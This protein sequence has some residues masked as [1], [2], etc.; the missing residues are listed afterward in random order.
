MPEITFPAPAEDFIPQR[1]P[2]RFVDEVLSADET[3]AVTRTTVRAD[4]IAA[5]A[6]GRLPAM[7]LIEVMAQT[8]GV[9]AGRIHR[10]AGEGPRP[11]LLLGTRRMNL[12]VD[13]FAPGDVLR[14][15]VE[16][17]FESDEGL[18][19]FKCAVDLLPQGDENAARPA[20]DAVLTVFNPPDGY[21]E[22]LAA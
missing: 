13:S 6:A 9:F 20:G 19:Q 17:A 18:W 4:S 14:C 1:P 22:K 15:T 7:A 8:I 11:G 2:M 16:K 5:D 21:F 12:P 3:G 10:L